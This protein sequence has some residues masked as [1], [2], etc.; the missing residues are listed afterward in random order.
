MTDTTADGTAATAAAATAVP[1]RLTWR[2]VSVRLADLQPWPRNPR[3]IRDERAARLA[4]SFGRFGQVEAVIIGPPD[5]QGKHPVYNGH[6]RLRVLLEVYGKQYKVD[7]RQSS[8]PLTEREREQL[9]VYLHHG[10]TGEFDFDVLTAEFELADLIEWG[11]DEQELGLGGGGVLDI[12]AG[13]E[14]GDDFADG[15]QFVVGEWTAV[16]KLTEELAAD[17]N[18]KLALQ[19][20]CAGFGLEHKIRRG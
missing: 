4:D 20:F 11:F 10:A 13:G 9:T 3:R 7:A 17:T 16:I 14:H 2:N 5:E 1:E 12:G 18:F 8:R 6:Q 15:P 19:G